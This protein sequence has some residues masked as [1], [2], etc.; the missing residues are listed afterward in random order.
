MLIVSAAVIWILVRVL[1]PALSTTLTIS[2]GP[3]GSSFWNAA[4]QYKEILARNGVTLHVVPSLGS[5]QNLERLATPGSHVD[6]GFV[7]SGVKSLPSVVAPDTQN[8]G[9]MS[10]GSISYAPL[11]IFYR[12]PVLTRLSQFKG[13]RLAIG[14]EGT[15]MRQFILLLLKANGVTPGNAQL[16]PIANEHAV[17][18]LINDQ[19]DVAFLT[20]DAAEQE[21]MGQLIH[22][23]TIRL[24]SFTQA[25]A[26][27]RRFPFLTQIEVPMGALDLGENIPSE[28]TDTVAT[29]VELLAR[30][31]L[32]P[33]LVDLL[34]EAAGNVH[35]GA[36]LI[37]KAREFPSAVAHDFP[38]S[39]DAARYYK[40]GKSFVYRTLPFWLANLTDRFLV[41]IV[42]I[43]VVLIPA[44]RFVP[45]LYS[46]RIRSRLYRR[47]GEL[48]ALERDALEDRSPRKRVEIT[49]RLNEIENAVNKLKIPLAYADQRYLLRVHISYVREQIGAP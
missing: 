47:Y 46:W 15:S 25:Q 29:S 12:G 11:F 43:I 5:L 45:P 1:Q 31:T 28:A 3:Q 6:L 16:L 44:L 10:L 27:T 17:E 9:L 23:P 7:Q 48:M 35:G 26:Y 36:S 37:Q 49:E 38:L 8:A 18:S 41:L 40:S 4:Q 21:V 42:P 2:S 22:T 19:I 39:P 30:D 20:G 13:K 32:D 33:A 14:G 24:F 34:V